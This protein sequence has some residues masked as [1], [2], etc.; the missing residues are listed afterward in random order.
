MGRQPVVFRSSTSSPVGE[1]EMRDTN[2]TAFN[3]QRTGLLSD[4]TKVNQTGSEARS[5]STAGLQTTG[6]PEQEDLIASYRDLGG[7]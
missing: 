4:S 1:P 2:S 6:W 5:E 3:K 7:F